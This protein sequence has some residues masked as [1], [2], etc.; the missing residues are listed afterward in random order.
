MFIV[1]EVNHQQASPGIELIDGTNNN[2]I[3]D[4]KKKL[5]YFENQNL[6]KRNLTK[7]FYDRRKLIND[8]WKTNYAPQI[9]AI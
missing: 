5:L 1:N 6:E 4:L 8:K 9:N 3:F 2:E 7:H